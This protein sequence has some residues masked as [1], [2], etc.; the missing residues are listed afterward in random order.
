MAT[1]NRDNLVNMRERGLNPLV[2]GTPTVGPTLPGAQPT[3]NV[4]P[5]GVGA[6]GFGNRMQ[7]LRDFTATNPELQYQRASAAASRGTSDPEVRGQNLRDITAQNMAQQSQERLAAIGT[8]GAENVAQ[9]E[10]QGRGAVD[11]TNVKE[12]EQ[13]S[14][15]LANL[16]KERAIAQ[17]NNIPTEALTKRINLA[18]RRY[19][20]LTGFSEGAP[21]PTGGP[22]TTSPHE[23]ANAQAKA[24]GQPFYVLD[25]NKYKVQ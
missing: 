7:G 15:H 16:Y 5:L 6:E 8:Q 3:V 21:D 19:E 18:Q 14:D 23:Q 2:K 13:A 20:T 10:A 25:G 17:E 11:Y 12:I 22:A 9:I 24:S 4:D 1:P